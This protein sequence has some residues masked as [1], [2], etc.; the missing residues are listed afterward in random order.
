MKVEV[1]FGI[2]ALAL[3]KT[4]HPTTTGFLVLLIK[5]KS[6]NH[7]TLT[8]GHPEAGETAMESALRELQ[9]ETALTPERIL[10]EGKQF[11][12][13]YKFQ[14]RSRKRDGDDEGEGEGDG[15]VD[16]TNHFFVGLVGQDMMDRVVVQESEVEEYKW[17][18][19]KD[20]PDHV[21]FP[22]DKQVLLAVISELE[23]NHNKL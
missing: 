6:G 3:E 7:W 5:Q 21:T 19:L 20:A 9:E 4:P 13:N 18:R 16:K 8:K 2:I 23:L 12:N 11:S 10:F 1:S 17:V 14:K 15:W 22:T